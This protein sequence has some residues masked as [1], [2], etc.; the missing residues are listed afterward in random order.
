MYKAVFPADTS[1]DNSPKVSINP[2]RENFQLVYYKHRLLYCLAFFFFLF[3]LFVCLFVKFYLL[4]VDMEI[5]KGERNFSE[6]K[7]LYL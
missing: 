6:A 2:K 3:F 7:N 4:Q 5:V 1:Y